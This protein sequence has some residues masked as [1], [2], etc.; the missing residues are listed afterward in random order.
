M[1]SRG[2]TWCADPDRWSRSWTTSCARL[3]RHR[4]A[5]GARRHDRRTGQRPA[6]P[7]DLVLAGDRRNRQLPVGRAGPADGPSSVAVGRVQRRHRNVTDGSP[8]RRRQGSHRVRRARHRGDRFDRVPARVELLAARGIRVVPLEV[9]LGERIGR[10][11]VDIDAAELSAALADRHLDVQT[12]RPAAA[13]FVSLLPA[14]AG[15]RGRRRGLGASVP[16]AVRHVGVGTS[17]GRRGRAGS[18][19]G[20]R[21]A[22]DRDGPGV[23]GAGR[24]RR[25]RAGAAGDGRGAGRSRGGRPLPDVLLGGHAR[26]VSS[27]WPDRC[28]GG[29]AGHRARGEAAAARVARAGSCRWR[30]CGPARVPRIGWSIWRWARR[31]AAGGPGRAPS[32]GRGAGRGDRGAAP[33][34]D[35]AGHLTAGVRGRCGDRGAR[36][37]GLLGV[38]VVPRA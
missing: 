18:G 27:R 23:R 29:L 25:G 31:R 33:G 8:R 7:A 4:G 26:P 19:P 11:G 37:A 17:G 30:R 2:S 10:E 20:G 12:S 24:G 36:G 38:V 21:L 32:R 9:R 35:S 16:G 22:G 5:G 28:G 34:A 1:G 6:R 14:G 15:C 13:E 3:E